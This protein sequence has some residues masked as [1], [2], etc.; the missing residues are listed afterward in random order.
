MSNGV[1]INISENPTVSY[2]GYSEH[3]T[4]Y[5]DFG[6]TIDL[7]EC[8]DSA[9]WYGYRKF[10][11][12]PR[13][14]HKITGVKKKGE[15]QYGFEQDLAYCYTATVYFWVGDSSYTNP[16]IVQ[17]GD[18]GKYYT[19][20]GGSST[21]SQQEGLTADNLKQKL[22]EQNCNRNRAHVISLSEKGQDGYTCPSCSQEQ[23]T[24]PSCTGSDRYSWH[25]HKISGGNSSIS[26]FKEEH[27]YQIGFPS[28]KGYR[29]VKVYHYS[30]AGNKALLIYFL[31]PT[32]WY[33]RQDKNSNSWEQVRN[34]PPSNDNDD[35]NILSL[36]KKIN[37][38]KEG[39]S[40]G[41]IAGISLASIG[42]SGS[43]I[44]AVAWKWPSI[45]SFIITRV[46]ACPWSIS[47]WL[48][49][50]DLHM[51]IGDYAKARALVETAKSKIRSLVGPSIKK[52]TNVALI[53][54]KV[55]SAAEL[56]KIAKIAMD[57]D[58]DDEVV[59]EMIEKI[60]SHCDLIWLKGVQIELEATNSSTA[61][62]AMS[63]ALQELPDSGLLWSF[64]IFMEDKAARDSKAA[65]A[66][67]RCPNSPD[68]VLA[69]ARLFWDAKKVLKARKWFQ[70]A[71]SMDNSNG[72]VWGTFVAFELD[73]GDEASVKEAINN[74]TKAEP[75]RGYDW[76]RIVKRVENWSISYPQKLYK[77]ILE[78]YPSVLNKSVPEDILRV[79]NPEVKEEE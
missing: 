12:K 61:Y 57:S 2:N 70:R 46:E 4:T 34:N 75:N 35:A 11:H 58:D 60:M 30:K 14:G 25:E 22:D 39:L 43:L 49:A 3:T 32:S 7:T 26:G 23:I 17:F 29:N 50:V 24:I 47:L 10:I 15:K 9:Q 5:N 74:C 53:Q 54:T 62:F 52:T 6:K 27:D 21:W 51:E 44:G 63:K 78:Y 38:D 48:L 41:A 31:S 59:K 37:G 64:S 1:T 20:K 33:R 67:K 45:L 65:D 40:D 42:T 68:V 56:L 71:I 77:Y 18:G 72:V 69:A 19:D 55:L 8:K 73:C 79:L 16:L 13:D 36:L 28:L 66:L 76:C